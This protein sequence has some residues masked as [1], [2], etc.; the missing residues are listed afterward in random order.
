[1]FAE[2][3]NQFKTSLIKRF[4][5]HSGTLMVTSIHFAK[6]Q[7]TLGL[8]LLPAGPSEVFDQTHLVTETMGS[9]AGTNMLTII[10]GSLQLGKQ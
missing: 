8:E 9:Y 4:K 5:I 10:D 2:S 6:R 3:E 7:K 1:M